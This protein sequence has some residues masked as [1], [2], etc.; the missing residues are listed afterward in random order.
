[1]RFDYIQEVSKYNPYH[2]AKG[3]FT[4]APGAKGSGG[5]TKG[6]EGKGATMTTEELKQSLYEGYGKNYRFLGIREQ[7]EDENY[8]VGDTARDSYDWDYE[9]D[10]SRYETDGETLPG[11]ATIGINFTAET[12]YDY[13][14]FEDAFQSALKDSDGYGDGRKVILGSKN[15]EYGQDPG[16]WDLPNAKVI[17][18]LDP[19]TGKWNKNPPK[20]S[21]PKTDSKQTTKPKVSSDDV[22]RYKDKLIDDYIVDH[23]GMSRLQAMSNLPGDKKKQITALQNYSNTGDEKWLDGI[24]LS[25]IGKSRYDYIEK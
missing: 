5:G 7:A 15:V 20:Q 9:N 1:M 17:A 21:K 19:K 23:P 10:R 8:K 16:E 11:A 4:S 12:G 22:K 3:R 25:A 24:D 13:N 6:S 18:V 14:D 2:D